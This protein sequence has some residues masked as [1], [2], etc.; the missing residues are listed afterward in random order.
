YARPEHERRLGRAL[1]RLG[2]HLTLAHEL[3]REYREYE[4]TSTAVVNA[5]VGPL[6]DTHIERLASGTRGRVRVMQSSGGLVAGPVAAAEPVRTMLSGP[7]G[8]VV[9]AAAAA[10]AAGL[11]RI[12]TLD[13]GGT[14]TDVAV[15]DGPL[16]FRTETSID[17]LPVRLPTL[18][19]HTVGAGGGSIARADSGGALRVG[20]E[21]AGAD[22]GPA[23]YG[24]GSAQT[25]TDA[26]LVL[27][28]LLADDF[29]GGE[30]RLDA[31]RA[32]SS[33]EP[34]ARRLGCSVVRAAAG[35]VAVATASMERAVRVITVERGLDPRDFTLL[36]FGGAGGLHAAELAET[37]GIRRVYVP[38]DPGL[39]SAWGVLA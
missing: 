23:C 15:V 22:P 29:L 7:A 3:Q 25:V 38:R 5:Y 14:S 1:R 24:R 33:L 36:A 30:M 2:L 20:P 27:G 9:G 32:R 31:V 37:L 21:S 8:G 13:M 6:M 16:T 17:G 10:R 11:G 4:R 34:L 39:L 19:I 18:D 26:H 35:V 28:R 12:I